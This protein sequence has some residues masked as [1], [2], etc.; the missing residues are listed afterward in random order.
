[1]EQINGYGDGI[2]YTWMSERRRTVLVKLREGESSAIEL[3]DLRLKRPL[4]DELADGRILVASSYSEWRSPCDFDRNGCIID[5]VSHGHF[6]VFLGDGISSLFVDSQDRIWVSY[7]DVGVFTGHAWTQPGA[8]PLGRSGLNCF[9]VDGEILW[10]FPGHK[11]FGGISDCYALNVHGQTVALYYYS[12][13]PLCRITKNFRMRFWDTGLS[14]C[15]NVAISDS[16]VLFSGQYHDAETQGYLAKL[17]FGKLKKLQKVEFVVP[18]TT[19]TSSTQLL[20]RGAEM[21]YFDKT[22]WY[23]TSLLDDDYT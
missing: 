13:F 20:G 10:Q 12:Q 22:G 8:K 19:I 1:M 14:G 3:P 18:S 16:R 6:D 5:P 4:V 2:S 15:G 21:H 7:T 9:A 11:K 17:G 23:K